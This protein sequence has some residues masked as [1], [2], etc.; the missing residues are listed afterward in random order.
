VPT[1]SYDGDISDTP[2]VEAWAASIA[3][4]AEPSAR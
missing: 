4:E 1:R 3:S 2:R